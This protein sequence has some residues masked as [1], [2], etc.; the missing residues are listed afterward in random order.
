MMPISPTQIEVLLHKSYGT[1]TKIEECSMAN[2]NDRTTVSLDRTTK[3]RLMLRKRQG[4]TY[5]DVISRLLDLTKSDVTEEEIEEMR[6]VL[7]ESPI[8]ITRE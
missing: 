4:D 5:Q 6:S 8:S 2:S 3:Q 7:E 1:I